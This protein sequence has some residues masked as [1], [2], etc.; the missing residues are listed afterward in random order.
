[1][2]LTKVARAAELRQTTWC[3][4]RCKEPGT[5]TTTVPSRHR[6]SP[7]HSS[8]SYFGENLGSSPHLERLLVSTC[9]AP[10][11]MEVWRPLKCLPGE[12]TPTDRLRPTPDLYLQSDS[13]GMPWKPV[14]VH[15]ATSL[16]SLPASDRRLHPV[17]CVAP[18]RSESGGLTGR[19]VSSLSSSGSSR[20]PSPTYSKSYL[21][22][23][24]S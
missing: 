21:C 14:L 19:I 11:R 17:L 12:V 22:C 9:N 6:N 3:S 24:C 23:R 15:P 16:S 18:R 1:M 5:V 8:T 4:E 7:R 10:T 13:S 2:T 20:S